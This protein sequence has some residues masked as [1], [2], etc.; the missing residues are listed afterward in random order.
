MKFKMLSVKSFVR[1]RFFAY[2]VL[3]ATAGADAVA[4]AGAAF[5]TWVGAWVGLASTPP[6]KSGCLTLR[7]RLSILIRSNARSCGFGLF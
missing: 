5:S 6:V 3:E 2:F 1:L 7:P 4:A